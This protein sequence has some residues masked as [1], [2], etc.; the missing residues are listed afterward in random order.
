MRRGVV[1]HNDFHRFR[2][3]WG[4]G[5]ATLEAKLDQ[6]LMGLAHEPLFQVFLDI[7]KACGSLDMVRCLEVLIGYIM[8]SNLAR[9][10]TTYWDRQSIVPKTGKIF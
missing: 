9:L 7:R 4:I 10:I 2:G 5:T 6:H 1:F 8:D 3:G